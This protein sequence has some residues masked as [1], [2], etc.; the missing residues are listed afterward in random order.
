MD[1]PF[2]RLRVTPEAETRNAVEARINALPSADDSAGWQ[3]LQES[4]QNQVKV[5]RDD[6]ELLGYEPNSQ[7]V[8]VLNS[9]PGPVTLSVR[10]DGPLSSGYSVSLEKEELGPGEQTTLN[11]RIEPINTQPKPTVRAILMVQPTGAEIPI[12]VHFASP[13]GTDPNLLPQK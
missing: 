4:I 3:S 2:G 6:I 11:F 9:M 12:T 13:P 7:T 1:S 8:E 5:K 10:S